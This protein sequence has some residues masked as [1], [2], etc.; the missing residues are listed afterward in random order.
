MKLLYLGHFRE[1]SGWSKAAL[2]LALACDSV[3]I[4]IVCRSIK[5]NN[6]KP[7]LPEK[8]L[9]LESKSL[10][11][12]T[13]CI[14]HVLP[15]YMSYSSKVKCISYYVAETSS[16][17]YS[18]WYT[19]LRQMDE[20]WVPNSTLSKNLEKDSIKNKVIPHAVD[21]TKFETNKILNLGSGF[22]FYSI[23]DFNKRKNLI[24][25]LRAF[26][27]EFH[28]YEPV[29]LI[30]KVPQ[31]AEKEV[32]QMCE[33]V[34]AGLKL[35]QQ[36]YYRPEIILS[37]EMT[38]EEIGALH[39]SCDCYIATA[40]NEGWG[41]PILDAMGFSNTVISNDIDGPRD[42]IQHGVNGFLVKNQETT[43]I[44][45]NETFPDIYTGYEKWYE[46]NIPDLMR[47]M[48]RSYEIG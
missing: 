15:H 47:Q 44:N 35:Y 40:Y 3:G 18:S 36:N 21:I 26:H 39:N 2:D 32:H 6:V 20:I 19:K 31:W 30:L 17:K 13:H 14:Q 22:K 7:D 23:I 11:G 9:E 45:Y 27:T 48:R 43:C 24:A 37:N 38:E 25:L 16:Q 41:Q 8:F 42:Y 12:V 4:D 1:N 5:I 28:R 10:D 46:I 29:Q 33:Q 34:R